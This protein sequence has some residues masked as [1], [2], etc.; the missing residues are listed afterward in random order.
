M[1]L[2]NRREDPE[3]EDDYDFEPVDDWTEMSPERS[4][5]ESVE[6]YADRMHGLYGDGWDMMRCEVM[7]WGL[8]ISLKSGQ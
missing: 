2:R 6:D 4:P 5:Y 3:D 8:L 1:A 7:E